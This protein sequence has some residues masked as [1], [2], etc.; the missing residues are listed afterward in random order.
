VKHLGKN[1]RR[2]E[3][4]ALYGGDFRMLINISKKRILAEGTELLTKGNQLRGGEPL[5]LEMPPPYAATNELGLLP[6]DQQTK[7]HSIERQ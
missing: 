1:T 2:F 3:R 4:I 6:P 7:A 5:V